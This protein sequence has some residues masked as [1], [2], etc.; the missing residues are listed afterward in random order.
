VLLGCALRRQC[1]AGRRLQITVLRRL[2]QPSFECLLDQP[3]L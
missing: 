3:V 1:G 2:T